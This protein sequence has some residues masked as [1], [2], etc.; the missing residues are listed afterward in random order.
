[1]KKYQEVTFLPVRGSGFDPGKGEISTPP[2]FCS[3][4]DKQGHL[5]YEVRSV[6]ANTALLLETEKVAHVLQI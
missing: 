6:F 3:F 4:R 1:M 2:H 5:Y